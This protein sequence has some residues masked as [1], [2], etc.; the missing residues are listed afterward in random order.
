M[1]VKEFEILVTGK[2]IASNRKEIEFTEVDL[3]KIASSYKTANSEV[4][5]DILDLGYI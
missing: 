2:F 3:T 5:L 4:P 1:K